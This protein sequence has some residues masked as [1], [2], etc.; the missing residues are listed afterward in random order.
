MGQ[1]SWR[2]S[3]I[4]NIKCAPDAPALI[5]QEATLAMLVS[6]NIIVF[7]LPEKYSQCIRSV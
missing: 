5:L 4:N 1:G 6:I 3:C 7:V 2:L